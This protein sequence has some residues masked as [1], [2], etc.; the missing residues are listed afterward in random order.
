MTVRQ[1]ESA[2]TSSPNSKEKPTSK[3]NGNE[4][5]AGPKPFRGRFNPKLQKRPERTG[6]GT[7]LD[8]QAWTK[9]VIAGM[10]GIIVYFTIHRP[11]NHETPLAKQSEFL[12]GKRSQNTVCPPAYKVEIQ[13]LGNEKCI[14]KRCGRAVNDGLISDKDAHALLKIA[15]TGLSK[16]GSD[17]GASIVDLHSGAL[18]RGPHFVNLYKKYP[19]I[20]KPNDFAV[21]KRVKDQVK[22]YLAEHFEIE[23]ESLY[24][25]HPTFFS[26]LENKPAQNV[27]DE[28]W[29]VHVDKETYQTFHYTS[30][31][32]LTDMGEDFK[33][34]EFVFVDA[35]DKLNRTIEPKLGRL[36]FFTSGIEN[37]HHVKPITE[38]V[39]Y[40]LT[41]GFTCDKSKAIPEIGSEEHRQIIMK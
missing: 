33:G 37:K 19:D 10:I 14:P 9:I 34:G 5:P 7:W 15:K 41:M 30:L 1:R 35:S 22:T 36:S 20:Y 38:G 13:N 23:P 16:G 39:R 28:Y 27:H 3:E 12:N 40:A 26:R 29:H 11:A 17:G 6:D 4:K 24:F 21:Y 31:L 32:Y 18:S 8:H 2:K 25:T